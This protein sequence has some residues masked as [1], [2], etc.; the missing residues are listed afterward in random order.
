[1]LRFIRTTVLGGIVF[2]V[3]VVVFVIIMG[4]ALGISMALAEPI[5][6]RLPFDGVG[7]IAVSLIISLGLLVLVCFLGGLAARSKWA[8][9]L[10]D[11]LESNVLEKIPAY[12]LLK[13]KTGAVLSAEDAR[14]LKPVLVRLEDLSQV[15]FEVDRLD[16]GD[17][18]VFLPGAPDPWAGAVAMVAPDRVQAIPVTAR[19]VVELNKRI[20]LG[21]TAVLNAARAAVAQ[22]DATAA[23][24]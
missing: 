4:E 22:R 19:D 24:D 15:G 18:V 21:S 20:G 8:R 5:V 17:V 23:E 2:L 11:S 7:N 3:P 10:V 6:A 13:A 16:A 1:M 9:A 12:A 14:E